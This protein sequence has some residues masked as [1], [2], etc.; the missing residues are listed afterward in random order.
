M[1]VKATD[2][3]WGG[4]LVLGALPDLMAVLGLQLGATI[5]IWSPVSHSW[6]EHRVDNYDEGW[7]VMQKLVLIRHMPMRG[8]CND[9]LKFAGMLEGVAWPGAFDNRELVQM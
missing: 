2:W 3:E 8:H 1:T 4:R 7:I 6:E 9:L 5:G